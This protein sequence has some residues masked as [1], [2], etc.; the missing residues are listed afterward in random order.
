[1][2]VTPSVPPSSSSFSFSLY[3]SDLTSIS[4]KVHSTVSS[5][6]NIHSSPLSLLL[7]SATNSLL[8]YFTLYLP[9][10]NPTPRYYT[11]CALPAHFSTASSAPRFQ[12]PSHVSLPA[13]ST[14]AHSHPQLN[15][16]PPHLALLYPLSLS[17]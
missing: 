15:F 17:L 5:H 4:G 6:P 14:S 3:F 11:F 16:N 8:S 9:I 2:V 10:P 7:S 1:M 12:T 13:P